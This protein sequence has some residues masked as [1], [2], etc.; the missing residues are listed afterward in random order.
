MSLNS[1]ESSPASWSNLSQAY[2]D[3]Q[4]MLWS[5]LARL[6]RQ[7]Y[8]TNPDDGLDLVHDF[9]LEA[10]RNL[11]KRYNPTL[12]K[13]TSYVYGAFLQ[14]ARRRI[15]EGARWQH[16]M[17][18]LEDAPTEEADSD[19]YDKYSDIER[20][21]VHS[22]FRA[23]PSR[24]R[25]I[26]RQ[27]IILGHS[28][29]EVAALTALSRYAIKKATAESLAGLAVRLDKPRSIDSKD[30]ALVQ[31]I[32]KDGLTVPAAA[33]L[34]HM[35]TEQAKRSRNRLLE[36]L[37]A[38]IEGISPASRLEE[39][40]MST[41]LCLLWRLFV[42]QPR[43][44]DM[45]GSVRDHWSE[46]L[47]HV[48]ICDSC[49]RT[50]REVT[51]ASQFYEAIAA[52]LGGVPEE[53]RSL[54]AMLRAQAEDIE[55]TAEAVVDVLLP[56]LPYPLN[57]LRRFPP[58]VSPVT[59]FMAME[60]VS[61]LLHRFVR[62]DPSI[63]ATNL[64][65]SSDGVHTQGELRLPRATIVQQIHRVAELEQQT[66]D[67]VFDWIIEAAQR[68]SRL[69]LGVDSRPRVGGGVWLR[70]TPRDANLDLYAHWSP[71][72]SYANEELVEHK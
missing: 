3:I 20:R 12:G 45:I 58:D 68:H 35:T 2:T 38:S 54:D 42:E 60:A 23:L 32:W 53:D 14:F 57:D 29:R 1:S 41:R 43:N 55:R 33:Q 8:R 49:S 18:T 34:L 10:W 40:T 67:I 65:L 24:S 26:L 21:V 36:F 7:G 15:V 30:W 28:E 4:P 22:A 31:A 17:M 59:L 51:D 63:K 72:T 46:L 5:A 27:R 16:H 64:Y 39:D 19:D 48:L 50:S 6:G 66:A 9:F 44:G 69:L 11:T 25:E 37:S 62:R 71:E 61:M 47:D 13:F 70:T 56:A 52:L